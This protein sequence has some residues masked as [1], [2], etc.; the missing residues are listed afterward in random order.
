MKKLIFKIKYFFRKLFARKIEIET[1][2]DM[3][4]NRIGVYDTVTKENN[5]VNVAT[6]INSI[7]IYDQ[8][9]IYPNCTVQIWKNSVTGECSVG[10][11][12]NEK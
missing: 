8:E 7:G 1:Y 9:E 10:W 4:I 6:K 3:K 11:W 12:K 5:I 2:E